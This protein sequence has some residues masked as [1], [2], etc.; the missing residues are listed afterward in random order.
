MRGALELHV[1]QL[2]CRVCQ[3]WQAIRQ[4]A[5][6]GDPPFPGWAGK[7]VLTELRAFAGARNCS[8]GDKLGT[9]IFG[10]AAARAIME[11]GGSSG[12]WHSL[13][14][15]LYLDLGHEEAN[16]TASVLVEGSD[17][18]LLSRYEARPCRP[19]A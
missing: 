4:R 15:Q 18:D 16:A 7:K 10:R 6:V 9:R 3:L 19:V 13:A 1:P 2:L 17:D 5:S 8:R 11:V 12:Q 14:Y